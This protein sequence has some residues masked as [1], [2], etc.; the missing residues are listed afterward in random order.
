MID[1][2]KVIETLPNGANVAYGFVNATI[3]LPLIGARLASGR[4]CAYGRTERL[5]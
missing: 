2:L 3:A 4:R 1:A 5:L